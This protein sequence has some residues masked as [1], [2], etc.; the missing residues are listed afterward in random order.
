MNAKTISFGLA[1][2]L[3]TALLTACLTVAGTWLLRA[4]TASESNPLTSLFKS[5]T[6]QQV[7]FVEIKN[8]LITLKGKGNAERYLMLEL[9]LAT[10]SAENARTAQDMIPA[11]RGA[12]VNLFSEMDYDAVRAL[13]VSNLH[14]K[15]KAAYA[16]RF[17]SLKMDVP[18]D[19]VIISK[20]VFQ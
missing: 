16:A 13:S 10:M 15:L 5:S 12:T 6:P 1:I 20:M 3:V 4:D 7:E 18:F 17:D 2:A 11:I 14:D 9:K 8:I 19:D